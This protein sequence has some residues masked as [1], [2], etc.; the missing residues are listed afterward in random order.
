MSRLPRRP[1]VLAAT[2]VLAVIALLRYGIPVTI[3]V[4]ALGVTAAVLVG[5]HQAGTFTRYRGSP[6][7]PA[8]PDA[9]AGPQRGARRPARGVA[10]ARRRRYRLGWHHRADP[11]LGCLFDPAHHGRNGTSA[12]AGALRRDRAPATGF[13]GAAATAVCAGDRVLPSPSRKATR[14]LRRL[15]RGDARL[16]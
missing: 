4:L 13:R 8:A 15:A 1:V 12:V 6:R 10:S 11:G 5:R 3:L 9:G 2:L 14:S 7:G 16:D